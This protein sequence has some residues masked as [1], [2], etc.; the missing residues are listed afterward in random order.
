[1]NKLNRKVEYALVALKYINDRAPEQLI[2][3]KEVVSATGVP[4]DATARVMQIMGQKGLLKS[5]Q[6]AYG[7]YKLVKDLSTVSFHELLV[8]ILGPLGLAKCLHGEENCDMIQTCNIQNPIVLLNE[9]LIDFYKGLSLF[10]LLN[11][12][13]QKRASFFETSNSDALEVK[14]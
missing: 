1:M 4:F 6:G 10:E 11:Q 9:K 8:M 2:T 3:A 7:G 13:P 12:R 5:E 14:R